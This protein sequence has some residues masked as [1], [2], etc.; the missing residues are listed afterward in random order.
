MKLGIISDI[1]ENAEVLTRAL[2]LAEFLKCNELICLGDIVGFDVRFYKDEVKRSA[3]S[4][5]ELIR[6]NCR[7]TV[8]GNHDL[9]AAGRIPEYTNGFDYPAEWFMMESAGRIKA[10]NGKVWCYD[11]DATNDLGEK[12][13]T[14]LKGLPEYLTFTDRGASC[15][16]SHYI[17]PDLTGSTT[18][19]V[20]RNYH[21]KGHW[22]FMKDQNVKYSFSGHSHTIFAGF[23]YERSIYGSGGYLK[24]IHS[25]PSNRFNLGS[26]IVMV[27]LPPLSGEKGRSGFSVFDTD[28]LILD[29]ISIN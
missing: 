14:F 1:H 21:M 8:A 2:K 9:F 25:I 23:A 13:I 20:E 27:H 17:Y 10:A 16:F 24:A 22:K 6:S 3:R 18:Q 28:N 29:I 5:V 19:Y 7:W 11:Q 12:E 4:C 26:E 15:L